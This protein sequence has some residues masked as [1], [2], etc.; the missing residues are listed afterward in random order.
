MCR[1]LLAAVGL[2]AVPAFAA[3]QVPAAGF[4]G[5][6]RFGAPTV[7]GPG[8]TMVVPQYR[9]AGLGGGFA[10]PVFQAPVYPFAGVPGGLGYSPYYGYGPNYG[11]GYAG[12]QFSPFAPPAEA[13][14][15]PPLL[16]R[17][18]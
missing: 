4:G 3:A 6:A 9:A 14:L 11:F 13:P 8:A 16:A 17:P 10:G 1:L 15:A 2:F 12:N 18:V 5:G 7:V